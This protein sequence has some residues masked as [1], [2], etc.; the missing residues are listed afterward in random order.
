[1]R[2]KMTMR[3]VLVGLI[4]TMCV[5]SGPVYGETHPVAAPVKAVVDAPGEASG[6]APA[7]AKAEMSCAAMPA[8]AIVSE[9]TQRFFQTITDACVLRTSGL[10]TDDQFV[11]IRDEA[12][13]GIYNELM[14][15][16]ND[17]QNKMVASIK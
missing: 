12:V 5:V 9:G 1:M 8:G 15:A 6:D 4:G 16:T 3:T 7:V 2:C 14:A 10:I 17:S 11:M 13:N